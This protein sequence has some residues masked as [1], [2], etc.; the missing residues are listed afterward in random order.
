MLI[1]NPLIFINHRAIN[2]ATGFWSRKIFS[3]TVD[4]QDM[5]IASG[6]SRFI[7]NGA[8]GK[9]SQLRRAVLSAAQPLPQQLAAALSAVMHQFL[10]R[11]DRSI[12]QASFGSCA[13]SP[14]SSIPE[15]F[16]VPVLQ[17]VPKQLL[18]AA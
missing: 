10:W 1:A 15:H 11:P 9:H 13:V 12:Y 17:L 4:N 7:S 2:S 14:V 5:C 3:N 8:L 6:S 18:S 16:K